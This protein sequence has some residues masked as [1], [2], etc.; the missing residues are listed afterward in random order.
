[1]SD[2]EKKVYYEKERSIKHDAR[3]RYSKAEHVTT[4][5]NAYIKY[6]HK[7]TSLY[8]EVLDAVNFARRNMPCV[9]S[10]VE[11]WFDISEFTFKLN[12]NLH[13]KEKDKKHDVKLWAGC[14]CWI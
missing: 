13:I 7:R 6:L 14:L 10:D 12:K 4:L 11:T 8:Q 1:M 2:N 5:I 3:D 9:L